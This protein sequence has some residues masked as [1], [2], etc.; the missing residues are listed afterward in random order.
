MYT[1]AGVFLIER[2]NFGAKED[3]DDMFPEQS[4]KNR[5]QAHG[6]T[7]EPDVYKCAMMDPN[8]RDSTTTTTA[9]AVTRKDSGPKYQVDFAYIKGE[10][11]RCPG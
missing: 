3:E 4:E 7:T 5:N 2:S 6:V 8:M 1:H 9:A 10:R 11:K